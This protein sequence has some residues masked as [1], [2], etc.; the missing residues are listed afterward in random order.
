VGL[1][2]ASKVPGFTNCMFTCLFF[3][4]TQHLYSNKFAT[5][6]KWLGI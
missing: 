4:G 1:K 2:N 3:I 5:C 6:K